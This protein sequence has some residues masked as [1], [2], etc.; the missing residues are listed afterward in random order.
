MDMAPWG[1][2]Y[3]I[4]NDRVGEN[5]DGRGFPADLRTVKAGLVASVYSKGTSVRG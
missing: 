2:E 1:T 3:R 5:R 4:A